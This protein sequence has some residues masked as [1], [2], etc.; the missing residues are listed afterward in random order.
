MNDD[1]QHWLVRINH[2][3]KQAM[4]NDDLELPTLPE[5]AQALQTLIAKE[6]ASVAQL[7][8]VISQDTVLT[9]EFL[10]L[11]NSPLLGGQ[12]TIT[13]PLQAIARLGF[14][15]SSN[16]ALALAMEQLFTA[17]SSAMD[18]LLRQT[19]RQNQQVARMSQQ[20]AKALGHCSPSQAYLAGS[21]HQIGVLPMVRYLDHYPEL[22]DNSLYA[23]KIIDGMQNVVGTHL[24][25]QWR[26]APSMQQV[27]KACTQL[28]RSDSHPLA[29]TV[30]LA[31]ILLL[32]SGKRNDIW[33]SLPLT[34]RWQLPEP[35]KGWMADLFQ[36]AQ[37]S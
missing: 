17:G 34:E 30:M 3:I 24:L 15:Y 27:P 11:T 35:G 23:K 8:S 31:K 16:Y 13:T 2:D 14:E 10:R 6:D 5:V 22:R 36:H 21:L 19:W 18:R 37:V 12:A 25:Q 26:F 1:L 29:D 9:A 7:A 28:Y 32:P 33:P 4:A 20:I